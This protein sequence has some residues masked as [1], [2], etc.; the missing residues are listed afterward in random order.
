MTIDSIEFSAAPDTCVMYLIAN[1]HI[2]ITAKKRIAD[3]NCSTKRQ[4][5]SWNAGL[6]V[7]PGGVCQPD[8]KCKIAKASQIHCVRLCLVFKDTMTCMPRYEPK[9]TSSGT[10]AKSWPC[11]SFTICSVTAGK[12]C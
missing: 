11:V 3:C 5:S 4:A 8:R 7:T 9:L 12:Y 2:A 1:L 10:Q 6:I